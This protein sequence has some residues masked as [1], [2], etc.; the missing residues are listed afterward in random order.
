MEKKS[1][2]SST[3]SVIRMERIMERLKCMRN[4]SSTIKKYHNMWSNFNKFL[5]KLDKK[6]KLWEDRV[7]MFRAYLVDRGIQSSTLKSYISALKCILTNDGYEWDD[8]KVLLH[9]LTSSCRIVNDTIKTRFLIRIG[10][11]ELLLFETQR[12]FHKQPYLEILYKAVLALGYYGL[13]RVGELSQGPH[14]IRA[15]DVHVGQ[16][17]NKILLLLYMSKLMDSKHPPQEVKIS[18]MPEYANFNKREIFALSD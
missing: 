1:M 17:K 6:P 13:L 9:S 14:V 7:S 2:T 16:N 4:H 5:L 15:C 11:L 8:S 10:L 12:K 3:I 18:A